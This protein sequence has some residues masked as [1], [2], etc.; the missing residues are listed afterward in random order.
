MSEFQVYLRLGIDHITSFAGMDHMVFLLALAATYDLSLWKP[1]MMI[2]FSFTIGHSIT[3][4]L[5]VLD[6]F[7]VNQ[8][9]VEF[10]IP[11]TILFS[12]LFN[13]FQKKDIA[14]PPINYSRYAMA[15]IFG[16]IHGLGFSNYL[17]SLLMGKGSI[18]WPLFSF[19]LG[20]E[21]GQLIIVIFILFISLIFFNIIKGKKREWNLV[22][23]GMAVGISCLL[24]IQSAI[25]KLFISDPS[26]VFNQ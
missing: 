9:L 11:L 10:L 22:I 1:L 7:S 24:I 18:A 2:V 21:A 5:A 12:A 19:N 3:L 13:I 16:M 25:F 4:A 15:F 23:S 14:S 17:K 26:G 8:N 6:I 20:I